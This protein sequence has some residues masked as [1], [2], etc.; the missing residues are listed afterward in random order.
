MEMIGNKVFPTN[1]NEFARWFDRA[2]EPWNPIAS[3]ERQLDALIGEPESPPTLAAYDHLY[4]M[5]DQAVRWL[6]LNSCP[7]S[8]MGRR[9]KVRMTAYRIAA[10]TVRSTCVAIE[11]DPKIALR[12]LIDRQVD[13]VAS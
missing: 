3:A 4:E 13:A 1:S 11:G 2:H 6:E 9:M 5:A 8:E 12:Q 10:D 7:D